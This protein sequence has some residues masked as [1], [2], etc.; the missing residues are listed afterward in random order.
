M[1][2]IV[3]LITS[4]IIFTTFS[5]SNDSESDLNPP[6][7]TNVVTYTTDVSVIINANCISCHGT[8]PS[9]NSMSLTTYQNVRDAVLNR[10]LIN[11]I[12]RAQGTAGMM[13]QGGTRLT[14]S[15]INLIIK[16]QTDGFIN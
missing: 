15:S 5:C 14:D 8:T 11:R 13:P 16:W 7:P 4:F 6:P 9:N 2:S 3:F 10:G 12:S 1:K